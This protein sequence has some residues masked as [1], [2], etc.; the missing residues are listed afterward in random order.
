MKR[1]SWRESNPRGQDRKPTPQHQLNPGGMTAGVDPAV[2]R[3]VGRQLRSGMEADAGNVTGGTWWR[4]VLYGTVTGGATRAIAPIGGFFVLLYPSWPS[5]SRPTA[6][7]CCMTQS[8][9]GASGIL[10]HASAEARTEGQYSTGGLACAR[11]S[12]QMLKPQP[13]AL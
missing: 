12:R 2:C 13:L 4:G 6:F 11:A 1:W 7:G 3:V 9:I 10:D 5:P 8:S